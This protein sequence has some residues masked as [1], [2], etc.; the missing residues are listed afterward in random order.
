MPSSRHTQLITTESL[1]KGKYNKLL[2]NETSMMT[3]YSRSSSDLTTYS[4][5]LKLLQLGA[6][7]FFFMPSNAPEE[8]KT[9]KEGKLQYSEE[10]LQQGIIKYR[11]N[12]SDNEKFQGI[13]HEPDITKKNNITIIT[14]E[15]TKS[16]IIK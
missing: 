3:Q 1:Q 16:V 7:L 9:E 5:L 13:N 8:G 14:D 12:F 6:G 2:S 10:M 15:D 11:S 4:G